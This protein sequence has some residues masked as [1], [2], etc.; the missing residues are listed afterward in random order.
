MGSLEGFTYGGQVIGGLGGSYTIVNAAGCAGATFTLT[1]SGTPHALTDGVSFTH[2]AVAATEAANLGA[3]IGAITGLV[4]AVVGT[5]IYV[6]VTNAVSSLVLATNAGAAATA[7]GVPLTSVLDHYQFFNNQDAG[8]FRVQFAVSVVP[9]G[10]ATADFNNLNA[11]CQAIE[12][13]LRQRYQ[14][15]EVDWGTASPVEVFDPNVSAAT[16]PSSGFSQD[17]HIDKLRDFPNSGEARG[18]EF[19][20]NMGLYPNYTDAYGFANGRRQVDVN[21]HYDV[22]QR[23]VVTMSGQWTQV[24]SSLA[25]A[26]FLAIFYGNTGY[27]SYR[28]G[29]IDSTVPGASGDTWALTNRSESDPNDLSMLA[30]AVE[31]QQ[32]VNG[33]RGSTI[34]IFYGESGQRVVTIRGT[35]LRTLTGTNFGTA[36]SSLANFLDPTNG[37]QAY[38]EATTL[39]GITTAEGGALTVGDNCE[40]LTEPFHTTNEQQDRTEYNLV[41]RELIQQQSEASG[42][43]LD[44]PNIVGDMIQV[45][46]QFNEVNDSPSPGALPN[47]PTA[48][49]PAPTFG[50]TQERAQPA[51]PS[52]A[53]TGTP[54]TTAGG[55]AS[56]VPVKPVDLFVRYEAFFKKSVT[57][58][59]SYYFDNVLPLLI[60][61]IEAQFQ[62]TGTECVQHKPLTVL[63]N[64]K[65]TAE[66]HLRAYNSSVV[67]FTYTVGIFNDLGMHVDPAYSGFAHDYLVQQGLPRTTLSRTIEAVYKAGT[68]SLDQ[69]VTPPATSGWVPLTNAQPRT[70]TRVLGVPL[71]GVPQTP[72]TYATLEESLIWVRSN[73]GGAATSDTTGGNQPITDGPVQPVTP[74]KVITGG[75]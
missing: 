15:L 70:I 29:L 49:A 34:E 58:C 25:R 61:T 17:P 46:A 8:E 50:G 71:P 75:G 68:M 6:S 9:S 54:S 30:F 31:F 11:A 18:Y 72:L 52:A 53:T 65:V 45:A 2:S 74:D 12:Y 3:A 40:L 1:V 14:R 44:D 16:F 51:T 57:D 41:Y 13:A 60:Q 69:F 43:F 24:P 62:Q 47:G 73:V 59:Y 37:G 36:A 64:N 56:F 39:P 22:D 21:Y 55:A 5:T 28:L 48:T 20:V 63:T 26:K 38:A 42:G 33:R 7:S 23:L 32:H 4:V 19:R 66:L 10:N 67:L 27:A 35:Y